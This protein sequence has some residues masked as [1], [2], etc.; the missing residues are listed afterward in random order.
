MNLDKSLIETRLET[1]V[2]YA[3]RQS[4]Q[5]LLPEEI[6]SDSLTR[7]IL[8]FDNFGR[9]EHNDDY[10][11]YDRNDYLAPLIAQLVQSSLSPNIS[12]YFASLFHLGRQWQVS[13]QAT[14]TVIQALK[15]DNLEMTVSQNITLFRDLLRELV[16]EHEHHSMLSNAFVEVLE[17]VNRR[18]LQKIEKAQ[19]WWQVWKREVAELKD[20]TMQ[21]SQEYNEYSN[22]YRYRERRGIGIP[23][24]LVQLI[25]FSFQTKHLYHLFS[26]DD[27]KLKNV[28]VYNPG[29]CQ[30]C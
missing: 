10:W 9:S 4:R 8:E 15:S 16:P 23:L 12:F 30:V 1:T 27:I 25:T 22:E 18:H 2:D 26:Q 5:E 19:Q 14:K 17:F 28:N 13:E 20:I 11:Q 29:M 21:C 6:R 7:W 24:S 3:L